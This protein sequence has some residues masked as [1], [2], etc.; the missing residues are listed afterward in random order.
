MVEPYV[1]Q[2]MIPSPLLRISRGP[3]AAL[4]LLV[5]ALGS[6]PLDG[7]VPPAVW[8]G[9]GATAAPAGHA[10]APAGPAAA[11]PG[12]S[13]LPD[14][15][16]ESADE[17]L[18]VVGLDG[19]V[20]ILRDPWGIPHIY[21]Q[22]ERDL[23]FAQGFQAARDRMFQLEIWRRRAS[24][25]V[26]E[27]LG[28]RELDRDHGAR[29]FRFRGDMDA[30]LLH[31]HPRGDAIVNS[32]VEGI[33]AWIDRTRE[34]PS[35]LPVEFRMLQIEPGYWTP[36]V[37]ISRHQGL[38]GNA[39]NQL[40]IGRAVHLGGEDLVQRIQHFHPHPTP[41]NLAL[42]PAVDGQHLV[43]HDILRLYSAYRSNLSFRPEDVALEFRER[44]EEDRAGSGQA[45]A[46]DDPA[47][48]PVDPF[49]LDPELAWLELEG[50][51]SNNWVVAGR[52][53][54]DDYPLMANDPHRAH[55][56][57]PL[58]YWAHL[59]APGWDVIGGGE[60]AIPGISIGHNGMGAW[61]LT[62]FATDHEDL[63]V[64]RTH[65]DDPT[66]YSYGGAWASME[67]V[68][69]TVHVRG[70]AP[71]E[72]ELRY[73]RHGPVVYQDE[74]AGIAYGVA[75]A[76][77]EVGG[78]PYLAS[79]R[80]NQAR[81]WEEF[82]E[83][84]TY[85][86]VPGENMV[87]ADRTGTIGW[88]A[89]GISPLRRGFSGLVPVPGDGRFEWDGFLPLGEL[90]HAVN[91]PEGFLATAN[92][93]VTSPFD[94]PHLDDAI[95]RIW[96]DPFRQSRVNEVLASGRRFNLADMAELQHDYLSIPARTLVPLFRPLSASDPAVEEARRRL[97][98][99]DH[100]LDPGSVEAGIWV[101][102][103]RELLSRTRER[104][105][106]EE[107]RPYLPVGMKRTLDFLVAPPGEFGPDPIRGR[108]AFLLDALA[109]AVEDLTRRFGPD[110]A[111][112]QYGQERYKHALIRHPL[113]VAVSSE[114]RDRL[115]AGPAPRGGNGFTVGATGAGNNQTSGASFRI[116]VDTRDWDLALGMN[117]PGQSGDPDSPF[118]RNLFDLWAADR[119]F[120]VF[121][122]RARVEDV[123]VE[124]LEMV[125]GRP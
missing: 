15:V 100:V 47:G 48:A 61:G 33:N 17:R 84:V 112:W 120:P 113:S 80:M 66:R 16:L 81:N 106:P 41:P 83:A 85:N 44:M 53:A 110:M 3:A 76:W 50:I 6:G 98:A 71:V 52:L 38:L 22:S 72:V 64:Y 75:A 65:P 56:A 109:A 86:H 8:P 114:W 124:R 5:T 103:E 91:P 90:P 2:M 36:E 31:Y 45:P 29:L 69:D 94:Y 99:W 28:P 32:F 62:I 1:R 19:S 79:L 101:A 104:F 58:R 46:T 77:L 13:A 26:A 11:P 12:Y 9:D 7:A 116:L 43:D 18:V 88:Q 92:A 57:P 30:E 60:P 59:N 118:Y 105:V 97:L 40:R 25:T 111:G 20:E 39:P 123:S 107:A 125:P 4:L 70:Q 24:G 78:A 35:L 119:L 14:T 122:S 117:T 55:Q 68:V 51:G 95:Y 37:V 23:F 74:E 93:N 54:Q 89:G 27:I 67:V 73:T 21:A 10:A 49:E 121:Y 34:D 63:F 115:D 42:D 87:W 82:R 102:V 96:A 108:D